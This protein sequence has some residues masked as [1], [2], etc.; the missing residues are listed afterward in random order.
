[1]AEDDAA[2]TIKAYANW[3]DKQ[4]CLAGLP[5]TTRELLER[6]PSVHCRF[7]ASR[8]KKK[9]KTELEHAFDRSLI[10]LLAT[11][12][13]FPDKPPPEASEGIQK[14]YTKTYDT[15]RQ[16]RKL[17]IRHME[18]MQEEDENRHPHDD[19]N[20]YDEEQEDE[21]EFGQLDPD[22]TLTLLDRYF[23]NQIQPNQQFQ[24]QRERQNAQF[25]FQLARSPHIRRPHP[26]MRAPT[27]STGTPAAVGTRRRMQAE[28]TPRR[29]RR[30]TL[31]QNSPSTQVSGSLPRV[32]TA[33][34]T[35][36]RNI[37]VQ[38]ARGAPNLAGEVP[39][40]STRESSTHTDLQGERPIPPTGNQ[41]ANAGRSNASEQFASQVGAQNRPRV[42]P[43]PTA[44]SQTG[45][46]GHSTATEQSAPQVGAQNRQRPNF[47]LA[48]QRRPVPSTGGSSLSQVG[49]QN[50]PP[51]VHRNPPTHRSLFSE[52]SWDD[53]D[54]GGLFDDENSI[55]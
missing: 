43:N 39:H 51:Q 9:G 40:P 44:G 25:L 13:P 4:S 15:I 20:T 18:R 48:P 23:Q 17:I 7:A 36:P 29:V 1:M 24:L 11:L 6:Y 37:S 42:P 26:A 22:F 16:Q 8:A 38:T 46:A 35:Q 50:P 32:S 33:P 49:A 5:T 31:F 34:P 30:R 2:A 27:S 14:V 12:R 55:E 21:G 19:D 54:S 45:S 41:T 47:A 28:A 3:E 53:D 10:V 52:D